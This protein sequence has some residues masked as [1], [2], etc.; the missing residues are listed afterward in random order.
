VKAPKVV[1]DRLVTLIAADFE[2]GHLERID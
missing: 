2:N 1:T